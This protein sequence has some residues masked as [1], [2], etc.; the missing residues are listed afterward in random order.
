MSDNGSLKSTASKPKTPSGDVGKKVGFARPTLI[1]PPPQLN[2]KTFTPHSASIRSSRGHTMTPGSIGPNQ[3]M[4]GRKASMFV[5][6]QLNGIKSFTMNTAKSGMGIGEKCSYW[7]YGQIR[8]WS[9]KWFTHFFLTFVL[10][11]Y[12]LGGAVMFSTIEGK[13]EHIQGK[14]L[15]YIWFFI[16]NKKR[17]VFLIV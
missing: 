15:C 14:Y 2:S 17:N 3:D 8:S 4:Y 10:V 13:N 11:L 12:T 6:D 16:S 7:M 5:F 1:I 9:K